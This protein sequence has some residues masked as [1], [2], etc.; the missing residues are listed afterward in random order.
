MKKLDYNILAN[1]GTILL[2]NALRKDDSSTSSGTNNISSAI[3][4][5]GTIVGNLSTV[6]NTKTYMEHFS[7]Y[8]N[9]VTSNLGAAQM[10]AM[11]L[12]ALSKSCSKL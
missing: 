4:I 1:V 5:P 6:V 10:A 7:R 8:N 12:F 9:Y 3:N 11:C 2:S